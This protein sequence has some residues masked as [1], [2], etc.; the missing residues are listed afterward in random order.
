MRAGLELTGGEPERDRSGDQKEEQNRDQ[1]KHRSGDRSGG[2]SG[3]LLIMSV[4]D[5]NFRTLTSIIRFHCERV[6]IIGNEL[7]VILRR[8]EDSNHQHVGLE[9]TLSKAD[10]SN[11]EWDWP[12]RWEDGGRIGG[13]PS[14]QRRGRAR[15]VS[16]FIFIWAPA[17]ARQRAALRQCKIKNY[18]NATW[19]RRLADGRS[20]PQRRVLE[21]T[22]GPARPGL[23]SP[24]SQPASPA[25]PARSSPPVPAPPSPAPQSSSRQ[26]AR[27]VSSPPV[28]PRPSSPPVQPGPPQKR[29]GRARFQYA[30]Q[31][32]SAVRRLSP[33]NR[34]AALCASNRCAEPSPAL[35][36]PGARSQRFRFW[37]AAA[38]FDVISLSKNKAH[39]AFHFV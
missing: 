29:A 16:F 36:A 3:T 22:D 23:A 9:W 7:E 28:Q 14:V 32:G 19:A 4:I 12:R 5:V 33:T 31:R 30:K 15:G 38:G 26:S 13:R 1:S 39:S 27:P 35:Q 21:Q 6:N 34:K 8:E 18:A 20:G 17:G 37:E 24:A 2:R 11:T 25:Q 10:H